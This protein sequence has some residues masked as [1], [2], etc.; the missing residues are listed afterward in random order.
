MVTKSLS[1]VA[2]VIKGLQG[3]CGSKKQSGTAVANCIDIIRCTLLAYIHP[4]PQSTLQSPG[5][6]L[7]CEIF[8]RTGVKQNG[9][10]TL[11]TVTR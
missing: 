9:L 11:Q 5:K 2:V 4:Q 1:A 7:Q 3:V 8:W 10:K 6:K